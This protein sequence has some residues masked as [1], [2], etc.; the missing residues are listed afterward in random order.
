MMERQ[1]DKEHGNHEM[2][3]GAM[4]LSIGSRKSKPRETRR[5]LNHGN[6]RRF[7]C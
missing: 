3:I 6:Y 4:Y 1:I 7:I 5:T 2:E